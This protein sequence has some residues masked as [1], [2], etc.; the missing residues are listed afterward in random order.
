MA[1][2]KWGGAA[3]APSLMAG[4]QAAIDDSHLVDID[5]QGGKFTW[6]KSRGTIDWVKE[7]LDR[8]FASREW[9]HLF[10]LCK[11][12]VIHSVASD[13]DPI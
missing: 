2:D 1:A 4:F 11:L 10:P 6:E 8:A 9:L 3:H 5:L 12:S 7:R 13:H